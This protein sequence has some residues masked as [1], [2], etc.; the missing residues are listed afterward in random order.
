[1]DYETAELM[2]GKHSEIV[3]ALQGLVELKRGELWLLYN[4][5]VDNKTTP[6]SEFLTKGFTELMKI[7]KK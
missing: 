5:H 2:F 4:M 7:G 1:M 3:K 6:A